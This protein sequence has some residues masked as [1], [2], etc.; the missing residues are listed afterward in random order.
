MKPRGN[1]V[2][3]D[4]RR[5]RKPSLGGGRAGSR[6]TVGVFLG[7]LAAEI[8]GAAAF[9]PS[10]IGSAFFGPM[11]IALAVA[12]TMGLSR[13]ASNVQ[14]AR[15]RRRLGGLRGPADPDPDR[16]GRTLH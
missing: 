4:F 10:S 11:V 3:V 13:I 7:L 1:I 9:L 2:F 15:L 12:G 6:L 16:A 5:R 8:L 14:A